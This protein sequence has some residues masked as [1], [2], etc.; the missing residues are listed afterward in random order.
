[1]SNFRYW[2]M[3]PPES[4]KTLRNSLSDDPILENCITRLL[5]LEPYSWSA[6]GV[7]WYNPSSIS[8]NSRVLPQSRLEAMT[9]NDYLQGNMHNL[10]TTIQR[11]KSQVQLIYMPDNYQ[12]HF[13]S[14]LCN[15]TA[16]N[17]VLPQPQD[18]LA[19]SLSSTQVHNTT[20]GAPRQWQYTRQ[21][22]NTTAVPMTP[23]CGGQT[24][25]VLVTPTCGNETTYTWNKFAVND[26]TMYNIYK[27][28]WP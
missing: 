16:L 13:W 27:L 10:A 2:S 23:T 22:L 9:A 28:D 24:T 8:S 5:I 4:N 7:H 25:T 21:S 12:S 20:D 19:W 17:N 11:N 1:M 18:H 15:T 14:S 3:L 26:Q 6:P